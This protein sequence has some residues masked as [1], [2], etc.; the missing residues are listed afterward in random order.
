M[1]I[2]TYRHI[3]PRSRYL[4]NWGPI[5]LPSG[6]RASQSLVMGLGIAFVFASD[7]FWASL[8]GEEG[9]PQLLNTARMERRRT[10]GKTP[11]K[12]ADLHRHSAWRPMTAGH[13]RASA[14]RASPRSYRA[15]LQAD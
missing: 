8:S 6:D 1:I 3:N 7:R 14:G 11:P 10:A 9:H 12:T 5:W 2:D 13:Q 15:E 4:A